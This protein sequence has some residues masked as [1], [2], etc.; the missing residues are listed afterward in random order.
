MKA[1]IRDICF[2]LAFMLVFVMPLVFFDFVGGKISLQ[3]NRVL[4]R[5]PPMSYILQSPSDFVQQFDAYFTDNVG[6]RENIIGAYN[7]INRSIGQGYYLDGASVVFIGKEGHHFHSRYNQITPIY[8]GEPWL[9]DTQLKDLSLRLNQIDSYIASMN[10]PFIMMICT[11]KESIYP[12]YYPDFV[13]K[14]PEPS[15]LD[16]VVNY[17]SSNTTVDLFCIKER[18][19]EEKENY[20]LYPK[21]GDIYAL[22]HYNETGGFFAYQELMKHVS[23]YFPSMVAFE[24]DDVTIEY[25]ETGLSAVMIN[26]DDEVFVIE[27]RFFS[28]ALEF[29]NINPNLPTLLL[30]H[31]SYA[32]YFTNMLPQHF[33]RTIMHHYRSV[34]LLDEYIRIYSPDLII[35]ETA[36]RA[37]PDFSS[38]LIRFQVP[39]LK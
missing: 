1:K 35:F 21:T 39:I 38:S 11:D 3:E 17:L 31:D 37:I 23:A 7:R 25:S 29:E 33:G 36:E 19:M 16:T 14:G 32:S 5:R 27:P 6:F 10:I 9:G 2:A 26:H 15:S 8:Q 24:L 13:I 12:E 30:L 20:L 18:L 22:C 34:D 4:A 28:D